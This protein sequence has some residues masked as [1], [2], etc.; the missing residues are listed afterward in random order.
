MSGTTS[1]LVTSR[2]EGALLFVAM[3]RPE[4]RNAIHREMLIALVDAV[5]AAERQPEVRA[6]ILHG[7][8]PV[9]SAGVDFGMLAGD[10]QGERAL[11][12][13]TLV[14]DMQGA[15]GRLERI[16]K[17]VIAAMHRYVPGLGLELALACDLRIATADTELGLPE[18]RVGLVPDVGG[19]TRLVRTVGY[20]KAKELVMTGRMIRADEALA[21]GLVNQV[22]PTGEHLAAAVRLA[23]EIAA[24]APLAVGLAKRLV[25]LGANA[26]T[27][28]F[29]GMELLAQSILL[30]TDDAREGAR[31][32]AERRPPRFTGR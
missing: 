10:V 20:A 17:P 31:A 18:V 6:V 15:L 19:T 1:A 27:Q 8:G 11:P 13:R 22:V 21:I 25:D 26:D 32:L 9:F 5:A 23:E 16:E 14:G 7:E 28:T 3:N 29:L 2:R 4:K 24:N 12:F 30:R